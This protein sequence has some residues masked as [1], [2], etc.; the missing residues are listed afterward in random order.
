M[1]L[2]FQFEPQRVVNH[3]HMPHLAAVME[4]IS[5]LQEVERVEVR[6]RCEAALRQ[7]IRDS[8]E[9]AARSMSAEIAH[10]LEK[11]FER[12]ETVPVISPT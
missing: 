12:H 5:M 1:V 10:R 11:S 3:L 4:V 7:K 6:A 8:A 9:E 2:V